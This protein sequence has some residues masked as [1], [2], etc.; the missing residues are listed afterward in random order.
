MKI[1]IIHPRISYYNGGGEHY[2]MDA[3]V[4]L[5][6]KFPEDEF[7][8]FTSKTKLP[9][10]EKYKWFL[11]SVSQNVQVFEIELQD[12]YKFLYGVDAGKIRYRWDIESLA[13]ANESL[14]LLG[15][16]IEKPDVIWSYYLM[17]FPFLI[18]IPT[19]LHLLGYPR[20][21]SEYREALLLQYTKILPISENVAKRWND[22]L[23]IPI[24]KDYKVLHQG[25]TFKNPE[26]KMLLSKRKFNIVFIGRLIER[27]GI[28]IL[29]KSINDLV[30]T[31]NVPDICLH[32]LGE[33][34]LRQKLEDYIRN[35]SLD[36]YVVL[37]GQVSNVYDY[38]EQAQFCIFP[39]LEGEGIMSA[40]LEGMYYNGTV[41]TT[42]DNGSEEFIVN[43]ESGYL[44]ESNN[45]NQITE[46][47]TR[48]YNN[49]KLIRRTKKKSK[50]IVQGCSWDDYC[51][52]FK[53]ICNEV[54]KGFGVSRS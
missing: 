38:L 20:T 24:I 30:L 6:K 11:S 34:L 50:Q 53:D 19:V 44:I 52:N 16:T 32:V 36:E 25:I 22:V 35:N 15:Q 9:K 17:D 26:K 21:Y 45:Q 5:S 3:I 37:H 31:G 8:I 41:V 13:F 47:I 18:D 1:Q 54:V 33:G 10:T 2:P 42:V 46:I 49:P 14:K 43:C 29:L 28:C 40:V 51:D 4:H 48:L 39:S 23:E 12:K 27:K 7:I